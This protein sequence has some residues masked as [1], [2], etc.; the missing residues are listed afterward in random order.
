MLNKNYYAVIMAGGIGSRFWPYSR[1]KYPKQFLDI[2][3]TGKS[4]I[5]MTYDRLCS[6]F[7]EDNIIVITHIDYKEIVLSQIPKL[8]EE[9]LICEPIR[10]NTAPCTA[11]ASSIILK[12]NPEAF[13]LTAPADHLILQQQQFLD[14]IKESFDYL[15][16]NDQLMTLGINA[17][18]PDTGYGYI[19]YDKSNSYANEIYKVLNFVEK[20]DHNTALEYIRSGD[21][22]WNSGMFLWKAS[23][24]WRSLEK[25]APKLAAA[26]D[27][28]DL[29][30]LALVYSDCESI[31]IDYAIMEKSDSVSVKK[32]DF[33]WSD[34]GTWG[35]IYNLC[36]QDLN[37]N[38]VISKNNLLY[39]VERSIIHN[40]TDQL[41]VLQGLQDYIVVNT[42]DALL[43]CQKSEEQRIKIM[44]NDI[45]TKFK[46]KYI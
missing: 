34:L 22:V 20:P 2:L 26:F 31:S 12:R 32:V 11:L 38:A 1:N 25:Y 16:K 37:G 33:G 3:G 7:E 36:E 42:N 41:L 5:Q 4:L 24:I 29:D 28:L 14:D 15:T 21:F 13:I 9:N 17:S 35:S 44:L 27:Y 18:R 43:I 6:I 45:E 10:K 30:R 39:E 46:N 19:H 8:A 23:Y 40:H